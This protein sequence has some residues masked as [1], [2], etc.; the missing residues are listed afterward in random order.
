ML[1]EVL[2]ALAAIPAAA[3]WV[4]VSR[5]SRRLE[6]VA[7]PATVL[8]LIA[9]AAA[10]RGEAVTWQWGWTLGALAA[11]LAGDVLLLPQR[12]RFLAGL[13]AFLLAHLCY[14]A[15][16]NATPPPW[17]VF[18]PGLVVFGA[19]GG[20]VVAAVRRS[21]A[22]EVGRSFVPPIAVYAV[23]ISLMAASAVAT[24]G[25]P[26]FPTRAALAAAAGALL[27]VASDGLLAWN[28]FVRLG[29]GGRV[30]VMVLYHLGQAGLVLSLAR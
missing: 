6:A 25:R 3:D 10:F 4:A 23:A 11:S 16:F 15:A 7:K 30:A 2:V 24:M 29:S 28:R 20:S 1:G 18:L 22:T 27:F 5:G 9:A 12:D 8:V 13:G 14:V 26:G 17:E 21:L 19:V